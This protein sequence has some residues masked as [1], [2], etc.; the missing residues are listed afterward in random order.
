MEV[1]STLQ[2]FNEADLKAE[3]GPVEG[4][5]AKGLVGN[6]NRPSER[7]FVALASFKA[8]TFEP[9]HWHPTEVFH[10]VISGR[11]IVRDVEGKEYEV[12]PGTVVYAPASM[13]GAHE[14]EIKEELQLLAVRAT[15]DLEKT[16]QFTVDK[17]TKRSYIDFEELIKRGGAS[18]KSMY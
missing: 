14:W 15:V 9:L 3:R 4:L 11:A 10:Y 13:A 8:G 1:K 6:T 18:F 2:V 12:G 7:I 5:A 17:A 16:L